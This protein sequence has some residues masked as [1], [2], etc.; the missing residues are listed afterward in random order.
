MI[1]KDHHLMKHTGMWGMFHAFIHSKQYL[2]SSCYISSTA[3]RPGKYK[4]KQDTIPFLKG[5]IVYWG[6]HL[7][8]HAIRGSLGGSAIESLPSAHGVI[9][10]S[11]NRVPHWAPR[12]ELSSPSAYVSVSLCVSLMNK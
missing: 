7:R 6:R 11:R 2:L 4:R 10:E 1:V 8:K 3:L 12:T 9:L 5:F